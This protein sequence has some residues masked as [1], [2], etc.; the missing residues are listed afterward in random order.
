MFMTD[1]CILVDF[2]GNNSFKTD[3]QYFFAH[4]TYTNDITGE[5]FG[6]ISNPVKETYGQHLQN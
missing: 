3:M 1:L 6:E 2:Y 5:K 4:Q